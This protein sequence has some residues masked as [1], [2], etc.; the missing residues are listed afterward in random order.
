MTRIAKAIAW[1]FWRENRT[2][3]FCL[4]VALTALCTWATLV[5]DYHHTTSEVHFIF[6][7]FVL[8]L[9]SMLV[10]YLLNM[11]Q[12]NPRTQRIG[13]PTHL[14]TKPI[15]TWLLVG[16]RLTLA[17]LAV[18]LL[19]VLV[20]LAFKVSA[21]VYFP[22][23]KSILLL[24]L[25]IAWAHAFTW[26]FT[27]VQWLQVIGSGIS[28]LPYFAL[29]YS[30]VERGGV[31]STTQLLARVPNGWLVGGIVGAYLVAWL[32]VTLDRRG[33][34]LNPSKLLAGVCSTTSSRKHYLTR[35]PFWTLYHFEM[36]RTAWQWPLVNA[37]GFL[38]LL[39]FWLSEQMPTD[40]FQGLLMIGA[41]IN[42]T[43]IPILIGVVTG[44]HSKS[45]LHMESYK[46]VKP[47][48]NRT[49]LYAYLLVSVSTLALAWLV[50][51]LG[52]IL[53]SCGLLLAQETET[54]L[55][56]WGL[57]HKEP[58]LY[59]L[60]IP[61][62]LGILLSIWTAMALA[63][64]IMLTGRRWFAITAWLSIWIIPLV[65]GIIGECLPDSLEILF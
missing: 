43:A 17:L 33:I 20:P 12:H 38:I 57:D 1:E 27:N 30:W 63:G 32:G 19:H 11:K 65:L 23:F 14:Y 9:E 62:I 47:V 60:N 24:S 26:L 35:S 64:I 22:Y 54:L 10:S 42:L 15:P 8:L 25:T 44:Q 34:I 13:Y 41:L 40:I 50:F 58:T 55:T 45:Q 56:L 3:W 53:L 51:L 59:Q 28:I 7:F 4:V 16:E 2:W 21:N 52:P 39:A 29:L 18:A 61:T 37:V 36:R 6:L 46:A 49:F 48:K 31:K 5:I